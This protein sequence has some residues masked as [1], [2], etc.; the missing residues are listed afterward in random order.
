MEDP[1][2]R[3]PVRV[4]ACGA[5]DRGD[6][7]VG[8]LAVRRLPAD[9]AGLAEIREVGQLEVEA[10]LD[11]PSRAA[12]LVVDAAAGVSPGEVVILPLT[13][14]A[15]GGAAPFSTHGLPA[16]QVVAL[17]EVLGGTL[18]RG[19]FVGLG[20]ASV[21]VGSGLSP[22]VAASLDAFVAAIAGEI[23]RLADAAAD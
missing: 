6:D 2:G 19:S 13:E 14:V 15:R 3:R 22:V 17:A 23:R 8:L 16:E 20:I 12:C 4:L 21:G 7:A 10:L 5:A 11:V 18:P 9:P 1:G